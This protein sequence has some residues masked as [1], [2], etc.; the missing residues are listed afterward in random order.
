MS[1]IYRLTE[2]DEGGE[3]GD[4]DHR[5]L[6]CVTDSGLKIAIFGS[7]ENREHIDAVKNAGLPCVIHCETRP[8]E[9]YA[10]KWHDHWVREDA[11]FEVYKRE[12]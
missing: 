4:S 2:Y 5:R 3:K 9:D 12:S 10:T 7:R 6:V 8:P 11:Y 1:E